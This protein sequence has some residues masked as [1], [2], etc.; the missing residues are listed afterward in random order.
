VVAHR[1]SELVEADAAV[2]RLLTAQEDEL[3]V[4]SIE[5]AVDFDVEHFPAQLSSVVATT[6]QVLLSLLHVPHHSLAHS[7]L[8][9]QL[10]RLLINS[11]DRR[12]SAVHEGSELANG[13]IA[14]LLADDELVLADFLVGVVVVVLL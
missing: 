13:L 6:A 14:D 1:E 8:N 2:A 11:C 12:D 4:P 5:E 3:L 7:K 10:L 9:S